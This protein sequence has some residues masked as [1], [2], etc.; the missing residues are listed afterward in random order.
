MIFFTSTT[1]LNGF[2]KRA[3]KLEE[4]ETAAMVLSI[5]MVLTTL[6]AISLSSSLPSAAD[7]YYS[8]I[9]PSSSTFKADL[10]ALVTNTRT[11]QLSYDE[12]W[13]EFAELDTGEQ[14]MPGCSNDTIGDVYSASCWTRAQQCGNYK[15]EG[16]CYNREHGWPKGWFGGFDA[17]QG[18]QVDLFELWPSDGYVNNLRGD[19]PVGTVDSPRYTSTSGAKVG[20]CTSAGYADGGDCFEVSDEWKGDFARSYFYLSVAYM[21]KWSCCDTPGA[22]ASDIKP[23]MEAQLRLWHAADPV[24]NHELIVNDGAQ[25]AQGNRSPFVDHPEWVELISDF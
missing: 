21:G 6:L 1:V 7:D 10:S 5:L 8:D 24:G 20:P 18:A 16:D 11:T 17:G 14:S 4:A 12:I 13:G 3:D 19:L 25:T 2:Q 23:W 22:N 15:Q 9:D